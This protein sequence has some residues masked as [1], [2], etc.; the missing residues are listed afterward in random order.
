MPYPYDNKGD[1]FIRAH[2]KKMIVVAAFFFAALSAC[3]QGGVP[4]E[5]DSDLHRYV[6]EEY[7]IVCYQLYT[8]SAALSCATWK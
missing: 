6:D 2:W 5:S 3:V 1:P 8:S 7:G 4:V